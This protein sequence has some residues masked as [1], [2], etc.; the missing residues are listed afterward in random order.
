MLACSRRACAGG[1]FSVLLESSLVI[2]LGASAFFWWRQYSARQQNA[3]L[4]AELVKLRGR[5]FD[6]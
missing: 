4:R 2:L 6:R 3:V 5:L 1:C